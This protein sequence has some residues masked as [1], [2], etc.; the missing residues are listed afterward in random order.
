MMEFSAFMGT[1][2]EDVDQKKKKEEEEKM[3]SDPVM[4]VIENDPVVKEIL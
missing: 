3:K 1:H 2:F 4:Q